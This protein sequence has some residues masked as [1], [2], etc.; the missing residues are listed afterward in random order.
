MTQR[1]DL[2]AGADFDPAG[3]RGNGTGD[4]QGCRQHGATRLLMDLGEPDRIEPPAVGSFNLGQRL[5]ERR[6]R[7]LVRPAMEFV[8]DADLHP[9]FSTS[10]AEPKRR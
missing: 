10:Y 1:Q 6:R 8:V 2:D 4:G 3:A 5:R 7:C 9:L